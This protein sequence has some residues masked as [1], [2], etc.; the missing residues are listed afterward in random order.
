MIAAGAAG[1]GLARR[2]SSPR[3]RALVA[4]R[5]LLAPRP[6]SRAIAASPLAVAPAASTAARRAARA[7]VSRAARR[8]PD[9]R[10]ATAELAAGLPRQR[11]ARPR[12]TSPRF[13]SVAPTT[14]PAS[15]STVRLEAALTARGVRPPGARPAAGGGCSP[16][17]APSIDA[18]IGQVRV[19]SRAPVTLPGDSGGI[20]V[21]VANDLDRPG[22]RGRRACTGTPAAALRRRRR[23]TG[24]PHRARAEGQRRGRRPGASDG[25]PVAVDVAAAHAPRART[26]G[27]PGAT[28]VRSAAYARAAPWVVGGRVRHPRRAAR[29]QRRPASARRDPRGARRPGGEPAIRPVPSAPTAERADELA[30]AR[31]EE[32]AGDV[33]ADAASGSRPADRRGPQRQR[34]ALERV[35]G[36]GTVAL[37]RHA[38]CC[39]ASR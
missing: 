31:R 37:A 7:T 18:Q 35:M 10:R 4:D 14:P 19:L 16:P 27:E 29:R 20:P 12:A 8:L 34:P 11:R 1:D 9:R 2:S 5:S 26:F 6:R 33:A 15:A 25:D 38:G 24:H 23:R 39:A 17:S 21:T 22:T 28:E 3:R 32:L 13:T 36:A 30:E